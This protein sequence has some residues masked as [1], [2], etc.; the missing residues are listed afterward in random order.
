MKID[1]DR[2]RR[3]LETL[4]TIGRAE[5]GG[6]SRTSFSPA[7]GEARRW[8]LERCAEAG[9]EVETDG[10]GNMVVRAGDEPPGA[11]PV[12]T[13]S[14]IDSVPDGGF[15]DGALGAIAALECVRRLSEEKVPLSRP[16]RAVV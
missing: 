14:H 7:D 15:L 2:L 3:D 11:K 1:I 9:L 8:Y 16:V 4:R 12:W 10:L 6:V 13:G 5:T